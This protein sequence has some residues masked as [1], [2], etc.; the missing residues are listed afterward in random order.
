[1]TGY[2][3]E[4]IMSHVDRTSEADLIMK[5]FTGQALASRVREILDR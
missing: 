1:M 2:Q 3:R 4:V 5:P